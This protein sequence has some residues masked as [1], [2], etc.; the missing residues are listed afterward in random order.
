[1]R[2]AIRLWGKWLG[3]SPRNQDIDAV[4]R[5]RLLADQHWRNDLEG[6]F[7]MGQRKHLLKLIMARLKAGAVGAISIDLHGG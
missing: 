6:G 4:H 7:G 3:E 1:M 2:T 5:Q